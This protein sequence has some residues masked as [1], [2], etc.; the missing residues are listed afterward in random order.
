MAVWP[1]NTPQWKSLRQRI[2]ARD[3][4]VCQWPGCGALLRWGRGHPRSAVVDH[5][6]KVKD[7]P[8]L[9]LNP[10]NLWSICKCH[11]DGPK[12]ADEAREFS[13]EIGADGWPTDPRHPVNS[14]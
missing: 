4:Y 8:D 11:H 14:H 1:Y 13:T 9:A 3:K 7:R 5:K 12:Q 2:L 10:S 6:V